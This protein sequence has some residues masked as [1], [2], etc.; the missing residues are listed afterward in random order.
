VGN[1]SNCA[2]KQPEAASSVVGANP[3][4]WRTYPAGSEGTA[5]NRYVNTQ[6]SQST[7]AGGWCILYLADQ[8]EPRAAASHKEAR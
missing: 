2:R 8:R 7:C 4:G 6:G 5:R 3:A 1:H